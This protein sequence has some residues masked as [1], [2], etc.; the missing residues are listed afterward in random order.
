MPISLGMPIVKLIQR[1][2]Y[3]TSSDAMFLTISS[4]SAARAREKEVRVVGAAIAPLLPSCR[5]LADPR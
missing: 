4:S 1:R 5:D 3:H 2:N